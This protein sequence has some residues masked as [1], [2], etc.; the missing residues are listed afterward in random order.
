MHGC[1]ILAILAGRS[2]RATTARLQAREQQPVPKSLQRA[3][4]FNSDAAAFMLQRTLIL[5]DKAEVRAVSMQGRRAEE[6][7]RIVDVGAR[8][9]GG[10]QRG[11]ESQRGRVSCAGV[12][13]G[14]QGNV[15]SGTV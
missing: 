9:E 4:L 7:H 2:D 10:G 6:Q 8:G 11:P 1:I 15:V 12:R 3:T 13:L 5:D 14:K